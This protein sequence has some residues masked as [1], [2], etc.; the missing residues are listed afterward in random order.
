M[1]FD[2]GLAPELTYLI[3]YWYLILVGAGLG[4]S[5]YL[6]LPKPTSPM[7]MVRETTICIDVP[8]TRQNDLSRTRARDD[9]CVSRTSAKLVSRTFARHSWVPRPGIYAIEHARRL[10]RTKPEPFKNIRLPKIE[11]GFRTSLIFDIWYCPPP[12]ELTY[13]IWYWYLIFDSRPLNLLT[14]QYL[15]FKSGE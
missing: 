14:Y 7:Q 1:I 8:E 9:H 13:L 15:I 12:P 5:K 11:I 4:K 6:I 3:W 10:R 2:I